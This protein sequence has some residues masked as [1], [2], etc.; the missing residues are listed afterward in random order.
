MT[1]NN[2][3]IKT[4]KH[5]TKRI[6]RDFAESL[7]GCGVTD[8]EAQREVLRVLP[9]LQR[10]A[11]DYTSFDDDKRA[12]K[13]TTG[14][15]LEGQGAVPSINFVARSVHATEASAVSP[16]LGLKGNVDVTVEAETWA[17]QRTSS[18]LRQKSLMSVELKTGHN[19]TP[20]TAH[21]AQLALYTVMLRVQ[22]GSNI[23]D[24]T[25]K[26][27]PVV[28]SDSGMLLYLNHQSH[29]AVHIAPKINEIKSL[30]GQRNIVATEMKRAARPRGVLLSYD[31]DIGGREGTSDQQTGIQP[32]Y[33]HSF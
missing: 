22:Q 2:F 20:Q 24:N 25:S 31:N 8:T 21:M 6:V 30:I 16:E 28:G 23:L 17:L 9:Q 3:T 11:M 10:F 26:E 4:A 19:Q 5:F 13:N 14:A 12:S 15:T 7:V 27:R 33:V 1:S 32:R 29:S 18:D